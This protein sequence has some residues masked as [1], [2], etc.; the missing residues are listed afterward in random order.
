MDPAA[1][2]SPERPHGN[3][4]NWD[5]AWDPTLPMVPSANVPGDP[6]AIL[7]KVLGTMSTSSEVTSNMGRS[8][9]QQLGLGPTQQV[10]PM[11]RSAYSDGRHLST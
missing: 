5:G 8:F 1:P 2:G 4:A 9:L 7:N 6:V 11:A 3:G 10:S